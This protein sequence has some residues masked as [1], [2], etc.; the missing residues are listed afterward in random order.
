MPTRRAGSKDGKP[1][2]KWGS[3]GK[4]YCGT[5]AKAKANRQGRA[6]NARKHGTGRKRT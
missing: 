4:R 3:S 1:C 2:F 5:G 6:V